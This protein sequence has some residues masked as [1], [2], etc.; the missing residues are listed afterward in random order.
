MSFTIRHDPVS[1]ATGNPSAALP[2][3]LLTFADTQA[4]RQTDAQKLRPA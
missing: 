1:R 3:K 4:R 2:S